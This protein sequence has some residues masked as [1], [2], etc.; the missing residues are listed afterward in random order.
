MFLQIENRL[1]NLPNN[2]AGK[3]ASTPLYLT[4]NCSPIIV[5]LH[6]LARLLLL[7]GRPGHQQPEPPCST[8]SKSNSKGKR[9]HGKGAIVFCFP[10]GTPGQAIDAVRIPRQAR[11]RVTEPSNL[12]FFLAIKIVFF[13]AFD[14]FFIFLFLR[15]QQPS[16]FIKTQSR[17][18]VP[19]VHYI[20]SCQFLHVSSSIY[21]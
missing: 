2:T 20:L 11:F 5:L 8:T 9:K 7:T 14:F 1:G 16:L 17:A 3:W 18:W 6:N 12:C 19:R 15:L 10:K 13:I 21:L 4:R